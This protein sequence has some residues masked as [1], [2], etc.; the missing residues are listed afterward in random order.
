M[1][2]YNLPTKT[3][4]EIKL[5]K[6]IRAKFSKGFFKPIEKINIAEG[7]EVTVTIIDVP[8]RSKE[9]AFEKAAGA[10]KGTLNA[11]KL[12]KDIYED[13]LLSTRKIPS[14]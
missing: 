10:W 1:I 14:L 7:K 13:R 5:G 8:F 4:G 11:K 12:I 6:T 3:K 2:G 9:D